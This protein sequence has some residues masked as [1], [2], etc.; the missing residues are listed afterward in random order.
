MS[1][2]KNANQTHPRGSKPCFSDIMVS[3]VVPLYRRG[4]TTVGWHNNTEDKARVLPKSEETKSLYSTGVLNVS[5]STPR[6]F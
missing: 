6:Y 2:R 4:A 5:P 1:V 3:S